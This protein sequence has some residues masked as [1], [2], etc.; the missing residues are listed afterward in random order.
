MLHRCLKAVSIE[1][2]LRVCKSDMQSAGRTFVRDKPDDLDF[3]DP[4]K[5]V[6]SKIG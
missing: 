2:F 4:K 1:H 3:Q 6:E 5:D